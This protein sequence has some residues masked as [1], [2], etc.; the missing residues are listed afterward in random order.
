MRQTLV[1]IHL[2]SRKIHETTWECSD[3]PS[4]S[5][6]FGQPSSSCLRL[7]HPLLVLCLGTHHTATHTM[8]N[9]IKL[10]EDV[11]AA[12]TGLTWSLAQPAP[13]HYK[14]LTEMRQI[15]RRSNASATTT[16]STDDKP[17]G[18]TPS[19]D[20]DTRTMSNPRRCDHS[21][22]RPTNI[23]STSSKKH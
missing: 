20:L 15:R 4:P 21:L 10:P 6:P 22:P 23:R 2:Q 19:L 18:T 17:D 11:Q 9:S 13:M 16:T 8:S 12:V 3:L 1:I 7:H 5:F 14:S